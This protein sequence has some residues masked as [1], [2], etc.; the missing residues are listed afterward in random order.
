M[1]EPTESGD[2]DSLSSGLRA[3]G[4]TPSAAAAARRHLEN[5]LESEERQHRGLQRGC[6]E[7]GAG[8][9]RVTGE[10][11]ESWKDFLGRQAPH[12][13]ETAGGWSMRSWAE[14]MFLHEARYMG[15]VLPR[16]V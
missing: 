5:W 7:V 13:Q 8:A 15:H 6:G 16:E 4:L 9:L 10:A 14:S 11:D 1:A 12:L 3:M 2:D